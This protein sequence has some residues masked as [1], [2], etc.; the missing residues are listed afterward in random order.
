MLLARDI[1]VSLILSGVLLLG[2]APAE[3]NE[4]SFQT[5]DGGTVFADV[6]G[7]GD[8]AVILAHGVR[9]NKESWKDQ[10]TQLASSGFR[11][12]AIDFRGYG[13]S[14][15][16]PNARPGF[17]D[18]YMDVLGAVRYARETG[19]KTV[20]VVGGSMGGFASANAA[21][22]SKPGEIDRLVMLAH[23]P[24]QH[25][26]RIAVPT[27]FVTSE[28]D[29]LAPQVRDQ[30]QKAPEPKE[31]LLLPGSAHA[32]NIFATDQSAVLMQNILRFV[33]ARGAV[34]H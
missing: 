27:L 30:Y 11:V 23:P 29:S 9:F 5:V 33:S 21:V 6:Y 26:E 12:I 4:V 34:A 1:S 18:M 15:G 22:H 8:R 3:P 2:M 28:G 13:K 19:A 10:A 17:E 31:L 32:Q 7:T 25:P 20:A 14:R 16:G 24:I